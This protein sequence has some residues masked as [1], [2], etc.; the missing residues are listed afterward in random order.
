MLKERKLFFLKR[1]EDVISCDIKLY[2]KIFINLMVNDILV[3]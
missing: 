2:F 1:W 3:I